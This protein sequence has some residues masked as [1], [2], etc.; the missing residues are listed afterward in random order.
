MPRNQYLVFSI[1]YL[2]LVTLFFGLIYKLPT[3]YYL[4][5]AATPL[6]TAQ[7]DYNF[8]ISK[9]LDS[10]EKYTNA[11]NTYLSFKTAA[12]K[13]QAFAATKDY[14]NQ[15]TNLYPAYFALVKEHANSLRWQDNEEK[16]NNID[17]ML[18]DLS[19]YFAG[20]RQ[21][22]NDTKTLEELSA[23]AAVIKDE[24]IDNVNPQINYVVAI[25]EF[26]DVLSIYNDFQ[27]L[28]SEL[29]QN[30]QEF[31]AF[32]NWQTEVEA[33]REKAQKSVNS[34]QGIINGLR[35]NKASDGDVK[36]IYRAAT[37]TKNEL[38]RTKTL[39]LEAAR[40]F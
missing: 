21:Q 31:T 27:N 4:L 15:V 1:K 16:H 12:A 35:Q 33:I 19:I 29:G 39:F 17:K 8:N 23:I 32:P 18:G 2:V 10:K 25:Y 24:I 9:T 5:H 37:D 26:V 38:K 36:N 3:T 28:Y 11:K 7:A 22:I 20:L 14:L 6:E 30:K 34:A 40:F 13:D